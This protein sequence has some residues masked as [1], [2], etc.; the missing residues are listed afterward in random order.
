MILY[1]GTNQ[2]E[3][4]LSRC[5]PNKDSGR[6]FYLTDIRKQASDM[7]VRR[8]ELEGVGTPVV[9]MYEFDECLL[10]NG[11]LRV[12]AFEKPTAEWAEFILMN[13]KSRG[14]NDG[15]VYQLNLYQQHFISI[16]QLV[17]ELTYRRLNSQYLFATDLAVSKL[18]RI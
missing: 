13:R 16:E 10:T 11:E 17:K 3:I 18:I 4:K 12:K 7:A 14:K 5:R 1:H 6:G 9:Q 2:G 8:C 15:V